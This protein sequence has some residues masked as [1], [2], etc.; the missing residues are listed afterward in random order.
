M[1]D[2]P[3]KSHDGWGWPTAATKP[4]YFKD[5]RSLCGRWGQVGFGGGR[6]PI[7]A[8]ADSPTTPQDCQ[9]CVRKLAKL[10]ERGD[11]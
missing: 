10:K 11:V 8:N 2:D 4:H 9:P 7:E 3:V 6:V 5:A 1:A